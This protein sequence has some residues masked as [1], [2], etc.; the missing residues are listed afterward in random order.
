MSLIETTMFGTVNKVDRAIERL[1]LFSPSDGYHLAFSGGK[2]SVVIKRLADMAGVKYDAHYNVTSV[3]PPE[4]VR[5]IKEKYPDVSRD[6]PRDAEGKPITM[7]SLIPKKLIPPLRQKRYCCVKLKEGNGFGRIV[8]TGVRWAESANR[9]GNHGMVTMPT[10]GEF[11]AKIA[12]DNADVQMTHRGGVIL[13]NDNDAARRVVEQ[14]YTKTKTMLNPIIDW[15]DGDVWEFIRA[16]NIPY[17]GLYD[18][19]YKRLGCIGCPMNTTA[20][21]E[22]E[23]YPKYRAQYVRT[24]DKMLA[25]RV[26]RG[27]QKGA[28]LWTSGEAVMDWWLGKLALPKAAEGQLEIEYEEDNYASI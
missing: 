13:N 15:T 21:A 24:F 10:K 23:R 4:L 12:E 14:C 6:V 17:C 22:L 26:R 25:E 28:S 1:R 5:F 20:E 9:T 18:C 7:W 2:D 16:E 27:K 19:G 8:V 11:T 3:D